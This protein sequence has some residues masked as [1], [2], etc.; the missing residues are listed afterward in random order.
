MCNVVIF[1]GAQEDE[2]WNFTTDRE[3]PSEVEYGE[4]VYR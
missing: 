2:T 4:G 3:V 1:C